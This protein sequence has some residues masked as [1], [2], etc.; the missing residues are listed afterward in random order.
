MSIRFCDIATHKQGRVAGE[1]V[2]G[3]DRLLAGS[4]GIQVVNVF[5]LAEARTGLREH[6]ALAAG[7]DCT[8]VTTV[9]APDDHK[10]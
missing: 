1:N 9:S 8:P 5:D 3:G 7:R 6:E 2:W 4:L 10:A